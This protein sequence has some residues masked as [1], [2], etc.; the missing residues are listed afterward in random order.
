MKKI[1]A[2]LL[3][4]LI[5][6]IG[7]CFSNSQESDD[8]KEMNRIIPPDFTLNIEFPSFMQ[9]N[10]SEPAKEKC[11][12][13]NPEEN[14]CLWTAGALVTWANMLC[15]VPFSIPITI[16]K[17]LQDQIPTVSSSNHVEWN[18]LYTIYNVEYD[19]SV[20]AD[21]ISA[22]QSWE[23]LFKINDFVWITGASRDDLTSGSWQYY[24]PA[25]ATTI[26]VE[27]E[28]TSEINGKVQFINNNES[29][30]LKYGDY[31]LYARV[32]NE[33]SVRFHDVHSGFNDSGNLQEMEIYW[34]ITGKTG[35][36]KIIEDSTK[37][38][39]PCTWDLNE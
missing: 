34:N 4:V 36:I 11:A 21:Y 27:W 7:S 17:V 19:V 26:S 16:Y 3:V 18:Y 30:A 8:P 32:D 25:G 22:D 24:D 9:D 12:V 29:Q 35:G 6:F 33:V 14:M 39:Q 20:R 10:K 38:L 31:I 15:F 5:P 37:L 28:R 1:A 23:W 2:L 13:G